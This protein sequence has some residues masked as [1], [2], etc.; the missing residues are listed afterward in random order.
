MLNPPSLQPSLVQMHSLRHVDTDEVSQLIRAAS[1]KSSPLDC[2][3]TPLL[4]A[5]VDVMAPLLTQLANL[6]FTAGVFPT[7]YKLGLGHVIP[8]LKKPSLSKDDP[9]NNRP[10]TNV[11]TFSKILEQLALK[12]LQ[13]HV[14]ESGNYSRFQSAYRSGYSTKTTLLKIVNDIRTV[15]GEGRC[16]ALLVLDISAAF[17]AVNHSLLCQWLQHTFGMNGSALDWLRSFVSS[18][19]QYVAAGG[20][21]SVTAPCESGVPMVQC[22]DPCCSH[23]MLLL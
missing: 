1:P 14:L 19:S 13:P 9:A 20:E 15:A 23:C 7:R 21:R 2:M 16:T 12:H 5:T 4:K 22:L 18:R 11:C 8:L 3:P 17:D 10:I 6:S